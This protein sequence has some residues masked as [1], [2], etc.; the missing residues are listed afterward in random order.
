MQGGHT[1]LV[2]VL[3][4]VLG[5]VFPLNRPNENP[6]TEPLDSRQASFGAVSACPFMKAI[7]YSHYN[8]LA[9]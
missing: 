9:V 6:H 8:N 7:L 3:V 1:Y 2:H 4:T 5:E